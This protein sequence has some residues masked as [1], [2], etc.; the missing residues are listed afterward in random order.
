MLDL[1][2]IPEAIRAERG[3]SR[4]LFLAYGAALTAIPYLAS[5][6]NAIDRKVTFTTDPFSVGV[7]SGDPDSSS[8]A[9]WRSEERR[10][11]KECA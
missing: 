7:A 11:G 2:K 10:V 4:R 9:L 6:A 1:T 5:H 8:V 3:M